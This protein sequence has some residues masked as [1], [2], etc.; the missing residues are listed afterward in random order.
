MTELNFKSIKKNTL[1]LLFAAVNSFSQNNSWN[2]IGPVEKGFN[3]GINTLCTDAYNNIYAGGTFS[4]NNN[5]CFVAKW[6]CNNWIELGG[7]NSLTNG[8]GAVN[9]I[10]VD[11]SGN[12]YA[13]GSF[14]NSNGKCYVAKFDGTSWTELGGVNSLAADNAINSIYITSNGN[15][16]AAGAFKNSS[17]NSYV[18]KW[19]GTAWSELGGLNGLAANNDIYTLGT[20]PGGQI[21]AAGAFTNASGK[22]YVASFLN[23]GVW[24]EFGLNLN[25]NAVIKS[26]CKGTN[27]RVYAVGNFQDNSNEIYVAYSIGSTWN[28]LNNASL[29]YFVPNG[30]INSVVADNLGNVFVAGNFTNGA[31]NSIGTKYV[32]KWNGTSWSY[33]GGGTGLTANNIINAMSINANGDLLAAGNFTN[34]NSNKYVAIWNEIFWSDVSGNDGLAAN[35]MINSVCVDNAENVY[36]AGS[37]TNAIGKKYVAK[38]MCNIWSETR[39]NYSLGA[40]G[41]INA[42]CKDSS[43]NIFAAGNFYVGFGDRFVGKWNGAGWSILGINNG[44]A[45]NNSISTICA[46]NDSNIYAAGKFTNL[47]GHVFVA[48]WN[49]L[50]WTALQDSINLATSAEIKT[51]CTDNNGTVYA[52]GNFNN[53][54]GEKYVAKWLDSVWVE[55]GGNNGLHANSSI[56][57]ICKDNNGNIFAAGDFTNTSGK[58]FVAKWNGTIWTELGGLNA[59]AANDEILTICA[60]NLNNIYA[61][62]KFKDNNGNYAVAKW[63]GSFWSFI[64]DLNALNINGFIASITCDNA[65]KIYAGGNF[66]NANGKYYVA[67]WDGN[68][69]Y[70]AGGLNNL[71]PNGVIF[72]FSGDSNKNIYAAGTCKNA[73]GNAY[74][75]KWKNNNWTE[76]G[77][78]NALAA[79][80]ASNGFSG[81]YH[82]NTTCTDAFGN[83]YAAG[84]FINAN[85]KTFVAKWNAT[86]NTWSEIG[87]Q[88]TAIT[89]AQ[90]FS[91]CSDPFGNI[92]AGGTFKNANGREY[93]AKWD[94]N[95]NIWTEL[96]GQNLLSLGGWIR[97][98]KSDAQGNIYAAGNFINAN[99]VQFVAK[100][101]VSN[102]T[103]SQVGNTLSLNSTIYALTIDE[104]GNV[105]A[106]GDFNNISNKYVAKWSVT[107]N[108]W[109]ELGGLNALAA[110]DVI[111]VLEHDTLG[112][113]Y[114]GGYFTN[115]SGN[116]YVAKFDGNAWSESGGDNSLISTISVNSIFIDQQGRLFEASKNLRPE[117]G[118]TLW[119]YQNLFILPSVNLTM[120]GTACTGTPI[121]IVANSTNG[122]TA[123][124]FDFRVN[125]NSIQNSTNNTFTSSTLNNGDVIT[126]LITSNDSIVLIDTALSNSIT[127]NLITPPI[128][129]VI[130]A[131]SNTVFCDGDS[132]VLSG[133]SG[134]LWNTGANTNSITVHTSGNYSVTN[135]NAC[136]SVASNIINVT[137]NPL[138][139]AATITALGNTTFCQ[140]QNVILSGN[141]GGIWNDGSTATDTVIT[142]TGNYFVTTTNACGSTNSNSINVN[143]NMPPTAANISS[144]GNTTFCFGDSVLLT[145]NTNGNWNTGASSNEISITQSGLYYVIAT[146][147]CGADTS[148][149]IAVTVNTATMPSITFDGLNLSSTTSSSYQWYFNGVAIS[150]ATSST[151]IPT[152]DGDYSVS[153]IDSNN[154]AAS[155]ANLYVIVTAISNLAHH[156]INIYPNPASSI[157]M[158]NGTSFQTIQIN[159]MLGEIVYQKANCESNESIDI[160]SFSSGMYFVFINGNSIK[161]IKN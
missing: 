107:S 53:I 114:A 113:L 14:S 6:N 72:S 155:A 44:L 88:L 8:N 116:I 51:I 24:S 84:N 123:P 134:G 9:A 15:I 160:S 161:L 11:D 3:G 58:R 2:H 26:I 60:D 70:E 54:N 100:W 37:F 81:P 45:A 143:V 40:N 16:F 30:I 106:A 157:I 130:T 61:A 132:V 95:T 43:G 137:V 129:A 141:N 52:A 148:N 55:L 140:G 25:A 144:N 20:S 78:T 68:N 133:N 66:T 101:D 119:A 111:S 115:A 91:I 153:I 12:V 19:D 73:S 10:A 86:T 131:N 64:G 57:T 79:L 80:G 33:L 18:A 90:I 117:G 94:P 13:A 69:W 158:V 47:L 156:N 4:N 83:V 42:M 67:N 127:I 92:Y 75:G 146:N 98:I 159:N 32:A 154:C 50:I 120:S 48:K 34:A 87:N 21:L 126:C 56:N 38:A 125:G 59:L 118:Y 122:G 136:G 76:L 36:A 99:A 124:F 105:Y 65:G 108:T 93:V 102:N 145:G 112:N 71:K 152:Q 96:G 135:S 142:T 62:G 149:S 74:V 1:I 49:G 41:N 121:T 39:K 77:G 5:K 151:Y 147:S 85:N 97:V 139:V 17:G 103:W 110:N 63:N 46:Y 128:P 104:E 31:F 7:E 150:G 29:P 109:S 27:S 82:I 89:N 23:S 138:P 35:D 22:C 28:E